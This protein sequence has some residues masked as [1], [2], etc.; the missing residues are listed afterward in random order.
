MENLRKYGVKPFNVAVIHGGPGAPGEMA[1][2]AQELSHIVGALEPLQTTDTLEGQVQELKTVLKTNGNIPIILIGFSWGAILTFILAAR[3]PLLVKKLVLVGSA[4]FEQKYATNIMNKRLQ[5]LSKQ[6]RIKILSISKAL[7]HTDTKDKSALLAQLSDLMLKA[8]SYKPTIYK[9]NIIKYQYDV[10]H[11]VW[12]QANTLRRKG[13]LLELG[14]KILCPV[15]AIH[16]NY[17]PH[18]YLG[19]EILSNILKNFRLILLENCGHRPWIEQDVRKN[20]YSILR[21]EVI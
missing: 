10:Y 8:D 16:G 6:E 7:D 9:T 4:P 11:T 19:V 20:F 14:K 17:D 1:P 12:E 5:R 2:V 13:K 3:Y 15:V 21:S 18:P